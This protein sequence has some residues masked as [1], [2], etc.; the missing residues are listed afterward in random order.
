MCDDASW[1]LCRLG[2]GDPALRALRGAMEV[3]CPQWLGVGRDQRQGGDY[4]RLD[5]ARAWRL[6]HHGQWRRYAVARDLVAQD[7]RSRRLA[8][9]PLRVRGAL[10]RAAAALPGEPAAALNETRLLHGTAPQLVLSILANGLNERFST[11]AAFGHGTYL[12][13]CAG[14]A[15]QY[16]TCDAAYGA[17]PELHRRLYGP[18]G[19]A[20]AHPGQVYYLLL[21]RAVL[22]VPI[23]TQD[24][25]TRADPPAGYPV[26]AH[27]A[28]RELADVPDVEPP[29]PHHS[30]LADI[31]PV[32]ARYREFV[33]FHSER[34]YPEY[35]I[36]Y[37]RR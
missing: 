19:R 12:T 37:H 10:A 13:E 32:A 26:F 21:C 27:G 22:G 1:R 30:L 25:H 34:V 20:D 28:R 6:E 11:V 35:L 8:A 36:A 4:S 29:L 3:T 5:L 7:L 24:G 16:A 2:D 31:G 9:P 14:K 18:E 33:V 15:D 17:V 23:R